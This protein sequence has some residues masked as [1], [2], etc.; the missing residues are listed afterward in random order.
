MTIAEPRLLLNIS[1]L[2]FE[3]LGHRW[4]RAGLGFADAPVCRGGQK[5]AYGVARDE[6]AKVSCE[7]DA[8]PADV[9]FQWRFN[10]SFEERHLAAMSLDVGLRSVASY[11]PR[12]RAD[13]GSLLCWGKNSVGLQ[14]KPC[15]FSI[16]AAGP[17][18]PLSNCN[19]LNATADSLQIACDSGYDGGLEQTFHLEVTSATGFVFFY[20]Y[21]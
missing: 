17:P 16:Q 6:T 18:E 3:V 4:V 10:N 8:D 21:L 19:V 12:S 1:W 13:Y 11:I 14:L 5:Q 9:V 2:K 15:V 20:R 7:L